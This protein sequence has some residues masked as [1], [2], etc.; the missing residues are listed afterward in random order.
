MEKREYLKAKLLRKKRGGY[1]NNKKYLYSSTESLEYIVNQIDNGLRVDDNKVD[2]LFT[3]D[4]ENKSK[5]ID[6]LIYYPTKVRE[7]KYIN[8]EVINSLFT[9]YSFT[10]DVMKKT[11]RR[12]GNGKSSNQRSR[13]MDSIRG[14]CKEYGIERDIISEDIVYV[15]RCPI[16]DVLL[17]YGNITPTM[18]SPSVDRINPNKGYTKDNI[19][20]ISLRANILKNKHTINSLKDYIELLKKKKKK[21]YNDIKTIDDMII[22]YLPILERM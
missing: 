20:V 6:L 1:E 19:W 2:L 22:E 3:G 12:H 21:L 9:K 18:N 14:R 7:Y 11:C 13:H 15:E 17:E 16:S 8:N 4:D 10:I 5:L